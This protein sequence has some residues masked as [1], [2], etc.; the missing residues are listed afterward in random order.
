MDSE[1]T[2]ESR[3]LTGLIA[4]VGGQA[5]ALLRW[6]GAFAALAAGVLYVLLGAVLAWVLPRTQAVRWVFWCAL[7]IVIMGAYWRFGLR[8]R[9]RYSS[10]E[11]IALL[12]QRRAPQL[13]D[14]P[15]NAVQLQG[16]LEADTLF[17]RPLIRAFVSRA[18][19][20]TGA[21]GADAA[22]G[23]VP[24]AR[25]IGAA[26][27]SAAL[28]LGLLIAAPNRMTSGFANLLRSPAQ[29]VGGDVGGGVLE[30]SALSVVYH[31]PQYIA[32][33]PREV[34]GSDGALMAV[35]GTQV[36]LAG[37]LGP[38]VE[39]ASLVLNNR[40]VGKMTTGPDGRFRATFPIVDEGVY[41]FEGQSG[42]RTLSSAQ[43]P[44]R[45][46]PDDPPQA[47]ILRLT[48]SAS[49]D[50]V[51][52]L[53]VGQTL[54]I[55]YRCRDDHAVGEV[56]LECDNVGDARR[57]V[58]GRPSAGSRDVTDSY[59]WAVEAPEAG[60]PPELTF[61]VGA[62]DNDNISGPKEAFSRT[63]TVRLITEAMKRRRLLADL[64]A[65]KCGMVLALADRL[66]PELG[67]D[68]SAEKRFVY[69]NRLRRVSQQVARA[70][71]DL[72]RRMDSD[73]SADRTL[74]DALEEMTGRRRR[75]AVELSVNCAR[76]TSSER[77]PG[78]AAQAL[79][80]LAA[81]VA[82]AIEPLEDDVI[83][84]DDLL[85]L[86]HMRLAEQIA[87]RLA[88]LQE[89]VKE[90][91]RQAEEGKLTPEQLADLKRTVAQMKQLMAELADRMGRMAQ[92]VE[93]QFMNPD[94]M[95]MASGRDQMEQALD[96]MVEQAEK[97]DMEK[98]LAEAQQLSDELDRIMAGM[99]QGGRQMA[100]AQF[101]GM[102]QQLKGM[103]EELRRVRQQEADL[104]RE[105]TAVDDQ[106]RRQARDELA[107]ELEAFF[108]KQIERAGKIA[109]HLEAMKEGLRKP[110]SSS[111]ARVVARRVLEQMPATSE[112]LADLQARLEDADLD[113]SLREVSGVAQRTGQWEDATRKS[114]TPQP[115]PREAAGAAR[116]ADMISRD[117]AQMQKRLRD[118]CR[119]AAGDSM[120]DQLRAMAGRQGSAESALRELIK[121]AGASHVPGNSKMRQAM[122]GA[123]GN[124][125]GA[126]KDLQRGATGKGKMGQQAALDNL[127][128]ALEQAGGALKQMAQNMQGKAAAP[129]V[130]RSRPPGGIGYRL[131]KVKIP[132]PTA[133]QVP[134]AFR[135]EITRALRDGLPE[136][137][138]QWNEKYYEELVK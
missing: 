96:R 43:R 53:D 84:L 108:N 35:K 8:K 100:G 15:I 128:R 107:G 30:V 12:M 125:Q 129:G 54:D 120:G 66:V 103:Q 34:A 72:L 25:S 138:R 86:A 50:G 47:R 13:K 102:F 106:L 41:H 97:G 124:M 136:A 38:P 77:T 70:G 42:G 113:G 89:R 92:M 88:Q 29:A 122:Q 18:A 133:Y 69:M 22:V 45:I 20:R 98:A 80:A 2:P 105:T 65:L 112:K 63:V 56:F 91:L 87:Q 5:R 132:D 39:P 58:I 93:R 115:T 78:G 64:E 83:E 1:Q 118:A 48:P 121:K 32:R 99:Q 94:A 19:R 74:Y 67:A 137:Y 52:E 10:A 111:S 116:E 104:L 79:G 135:S 28:A 57:L 110:C 62:R 7:P 44:V 68:T 71:R 6:H 11:Q 114:E 3:Y 24:V 61:R 37:R 9:K 73:P 130:S 49:A 85:K 75:E 23:D 126:G 31:Y 17:S 26:L 16:E 117:L 127:D 131:D 59:G 81:V 134:E 82:D 101:G 36:A 33:Q 27:L 90:L 76:V 40:E 95:K 14:T 123:A 51:V 119:Q 21:L 46:E 60:A 109:R 55:A 4:E